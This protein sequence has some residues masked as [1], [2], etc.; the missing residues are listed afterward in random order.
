MC[1]NS[2]PNIDARGWNPNSS[3]KCA[4]WFVEN[5]ASGNCACTTRRSRHTVRHRSWCHQDRTLAC[6]C[7]RRRTRS[8]PMVSKPGALG[9][10]SG[11]P[12]CGGGGAEAALCGSTTG[13]CVISLCSRD[14][15]TFLLRAGRPGALVVSGQSQRRPAPGRR[16]FLFNIERRRSV[17]VPRRTL[18][19]RP[20]G[21]PRARGAH[22]SAVRDAAMRQRA[23]RTRAGRPRWTGRGAWRT[24][25]GP[26]TWRCSWRAALE[27]LAAVC[28]RS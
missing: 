2:A 23:P 26:T 6:L 27:G 11:W 7:S 5:R 9:S 12:S 18:R 16:A 15:D 25:A 19:P 13:S 10:R 28:K 22:R 3:T 4:F 14:S 20:P 1:W 21:L 8:R 24:A 17:E